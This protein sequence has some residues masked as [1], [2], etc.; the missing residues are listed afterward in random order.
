MRKTATLQAT[1]LTA[2][3]PVNPSSFTF[4][5]SVSLCLSNYNTGLDQCLLKVLLHRVVIGIVHLPAG[6][7]NHIVTW[8]RPV[9][10]PAESPH[11][12]LGPIAPYRI[13]EFLPRYKSDTT[14]M[15]V[16]LFV[17]DY[18]QT[19]VWR[20]YTAP[21]FE[22]TR[23]IRTGLNGIHVVRRSGACDPLRGDERVR[24]GLPWWP[25]EHGNRES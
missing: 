10:I 16:S 13:P 14:G 18:Q 21:M 15:V 8:E 25:C 22:H 4:E 7:E 9:Q 12:A 6:Y 5:E 23:Y 2:A 3:V 20:V 19:Y 17:P 1:P 11:A 24:H